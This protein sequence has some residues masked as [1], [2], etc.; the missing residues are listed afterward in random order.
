MTYFGAHA[1]QFRMKMAAARVCG[2]DRYNLF[3]FLKRIILTSRFVSRLNT[4]SVFLLFYYCFLL[5]YIEI[6]WSGTVYK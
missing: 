1:I 5:L 4:F 3:N 6:M 2:I